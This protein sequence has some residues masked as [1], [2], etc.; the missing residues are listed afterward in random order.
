MTIQPHHFSQT[1]GQEHLKS[2]KYV[3]YMKEADLE[4]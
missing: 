4:T 2:H 3:N 1:L